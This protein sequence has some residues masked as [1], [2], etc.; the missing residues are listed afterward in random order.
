M[1]QL[2]SDD[3]YSRNIKISQVLSDLFEP[4]PEVASQELMVF[5]IN[6]L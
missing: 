4:A 3:D 1:G 2:S 5:T 6:Y